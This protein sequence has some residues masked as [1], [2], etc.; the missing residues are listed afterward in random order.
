MVSRL[1]VDKPKWLSNK[2]MDSTVVAHAKHRA[3]L[4]IHEFRESISI[5]ENVELAT[6]EK[7]I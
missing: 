4:Q 7:Y 3:V 6:T 1:K 5:F 2:K